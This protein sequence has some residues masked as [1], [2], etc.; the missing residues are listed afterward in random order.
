MRPSAPFRLGDHL[1]EPATN[2]LRRP[3]AEPVQLEPKVMDVL[4]RLARDPGELV[5]RE[6]L[7]DSV[8]PGLYV[9]EHAL[10]RCISDLRKH[11][12]DAASAPRYLETIRKRGYRL[13]AP[14]VTVGIRPPRP[15]VGAGHAPRRSAWRRRLPWA[16]SVGLALLSTVAWLRAAAMAPAPLPS[17]VPLTSFAGSEL[18]PAL[19]PDGTMLAFAWSGPEGDDY[20][21][22]LLPLAGGMPR[23]LTAGPAEDKNPGWSPDGERLA[24]VRA[25]GAASGIYVVAV[26]GA[27]VR[28]L[29]AT[30]SGD[31]PDLAWSPD[32]RHLYF[33]DRDAGGGPMRIERLDL[34]SRRRAVIT[35]PPR[36]LV[37]DRDLALSPNG[38]RLAFARAVMP[39]VEELWV[40]TAGGEAHRLT[41]DA[42]SINGLEWAPDGS[43]ILFSS[44]RDGFSRLWRI[45]PSGGT[46]EPVLGLGDGAQDPTFAAGRLV[47]ERRRYDTNIWSLALDGVGSPPELVIRSTRWDSSPA[48]SPDGSRIAF[49]TDRAGPPEVWIANRD[50]E[51]V[52]R[53]A[54]GHPALSPA[55][56]SPD[57]GELVFALQ[58]GAH[59][60]LYRSSSA[61]GRPSRLT[62]GPAND[63]APSFSR[64]G[65]WVYFGSDRS[66][67]WQ[68]WKLPAGGGE[69]VR[70]TRWGGLRARESV[71]GTLVFFTRADRGGLWSLPASG[72][73]QRQVLSARQ[74][75][76]WSGWDVGPRSL[77]FGEPASGPA[78]SAVIRRLDLASRQVAAASAPFR[79]FHV[80]GLGLSLA[81]DES[82]LV[83]GRVDGDDSDLVLV[84][85]AGWPGR[86]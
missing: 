64:D 45:D 76:P 81:A 10:F 8:W 53:V 50:G 69:A 73:A 3:G 14:V 13:I 65:R 54:A 66:G 60:H 83:F 85:G 57:G 78:A 67:G 1:V 20:D 71:D 75:A 36:H 30:S 59:S 28:K 77:Y 46:P 2:R 55:S 17:T 42:T 74:V 72:G 84:E 63:V 34:V 32:G 70:V 82:F 35:R 43:S 80:A 49:V 27:G 86:R 40:S 48:V 18:D 44:A 33:A 39:G 12:G 41:G 31:V 47:F 23:R 4:L 79:G 24:F 6:E 56:W 58:D 16:A 38:R 25:A 11:L 19:S 7:F 15:R 68:V 21:L 22:Y 9:T 26:D 61:G 37:G 62:T 5:T 51:A 52:A 29:T